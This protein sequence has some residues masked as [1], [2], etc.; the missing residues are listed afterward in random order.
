MSLILFNYNSCN[1]KKCVF[2]LAWLI[3]EPVSP[4]VR[5]RAGVIK[6]YLKYCKHTCYMEVAQGFC[7]LIL[8]GLKNGLIGFCALILLGLKNG[9]TGVWA[10]ILLGLK[11][12]VTA[13][14]T[15]SQPVL[16][17]TIDNG[18]QSD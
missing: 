14:G 10:L 13:C 9:L 1:G 17:E 8:L 11:N 3:S 7:I 18:Q 12:G 16:L 5:I 6:C 15:D 4:N 2:G